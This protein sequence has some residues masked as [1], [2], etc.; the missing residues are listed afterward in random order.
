VAFNAMQ[1]RIADHF[2]ERV[3]ILAAISH[4]LQ[5]PITRMRLRTDLLDDSTLKQKLQNDLA[6]MQALIEEGID[7][8][9]SAE[10]TTE[11]PIATDV[12]ALLESLVYDY[13]DSGKQVGLIGRVDTP[14]MTSPCT[15]RRIIT[16]L[17]DNALK[18][19]CEVEIAVAKQTPDRI[20]IAVR[21]SGRGSRNPN[22]VRCSNHF[23]ALK[24]REIAMPA[25]RARD[26]RSRTG[27]RP[28]SE[29]N[30]DSRT[31]PAVGWRRS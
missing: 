5:S 2:A 8:A 29:A 4:D 16:N 17:V 12:Q 6:A 20:S 11:T 13:A 7:L 1:R 18:F 9:R 10:R 21:D 23:I 31:G 22:S 27:C 19:G 30:F 28:R 14:V 25:A 26:S 24:D 15:L 3:R